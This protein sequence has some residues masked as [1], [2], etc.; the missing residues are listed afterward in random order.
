L[1]ASAKEREAAQA[2]IRFLTAPAAG[3]ILKANGV[4]PA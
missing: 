4:D 1:S 2:L 3:P